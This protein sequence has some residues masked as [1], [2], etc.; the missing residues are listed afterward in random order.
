[1]LHVPADTFFL[2]RYLGKKNNRD[3]HAFTDLYL[4]QVYEVL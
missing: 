2:S 1:M 3:P 4:V